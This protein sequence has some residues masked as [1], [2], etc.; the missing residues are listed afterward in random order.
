MAKENIEKFFETAMVDPVL[1]GKV[2]ALTAKSK[3]EFTA[4]ELLEWGAARPLTDEEAMGAAGGLLLI[5]LPSI[6]CSVC[7]TLWKPSEQPCCPNC[8][9]GMNA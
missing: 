3:Y 7:G 1:A 9:S 5:S 2:A 6:E 4:A 8:G